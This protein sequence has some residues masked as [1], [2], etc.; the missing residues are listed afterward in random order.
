MSHRSLRALLLCSFACLFAHPAAAQITGN[1]IEVSAQAG[2]SAPDA[3][4]H[5]KSGPGFGGSLGWRAQS[6]FVLEAQALYASSKADTLPEQKQSFFTYGVDARMN[7]RPGDNKVVPYALV[8]FGAGSSQTTGKP[9]DNLTRGI[10]ALGLGV[11]INLRGNQ[12]A[13]VRLQ[14]RDTYFK[15]RDSKEFSQ[16]MALTLGLHWIFGGKVKDSDLDGVR[17]W[18]DQCPNTPIGAKV[19]ANGCPHDS[20]GDG[21]PDGIDKCP[22]TPKGCPVDRAGC[23]TDS[24]GDGVCDGLDKCPDTPKGATVDA[25]GCPSDS[26][27]D[28]VPDGIDQCPNTPKGATVD[29]KGC[30]M[31][32]DGDGVPD[33]LDK[34]PGTP[35]GVKVDADGCA[36]EYQD[37]HAQLVDTGM[38]RL[39]NINFETN[40]ATLLPESYP[41]LDNVGH[42]LKQYPDLKIEIG[43][44]TD[45]KGTAKKNQKLSADRAKA[46]KDYLTKTF[47]DLN[48]GNLTTK[49]YGSSK[50][51]VP[52]NNAANMAKNRRVEFVVLNKDALRKQTQGH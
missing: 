51:L 18:L 17:E 32:S 26:D 36:K 4:A 19:D 20:D 50:P 15:E 7:M 37:L 14:A 41:S 35:P 39:D 16:N 48:A 44:H 5:M 45:N 49:G 52:N 9:P 3:R 10:G 21:V 2:A 12:W 29:A 25:N 42:V 43:G 22:N 11:L 31:D 1:P 38:M 40:K 47:P 33:G 8:G 28:G 46:V 24:D 13:Y 6:W 30:P 34:C 27:G 23:S